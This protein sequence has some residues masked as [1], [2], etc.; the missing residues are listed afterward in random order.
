[1]HRQ[2]IP[3]MPLRS[4]KYWRN[5]VWHVPITLIVK[6]CMSFFNILTMP[7][8]TPNTSWKDIL[9]PEIVLFI[10]WFFSA[11]PWCSYLLNY[12]FCTY[13]L[14]WWH[15]WHM[16]FFLIYHLD[17]LNRPAWSRGVADICCM[18]MATWQAWYGSVSNKGTWCK[19]F[20]N[21]T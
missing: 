7:S 19:H 18:S 12:E 16:T 10:H 8:I 5:K 4:V 9:H 13:D 21:G 6:F 14:S 17:L 11:N 20:V 2:G 1:M 3:V 15:L